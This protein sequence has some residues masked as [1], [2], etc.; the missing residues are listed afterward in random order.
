MHNY[1]CMWKSPAPHELYYFGLFNFVHSNLFHV[2][3]IFKSSP[4]KQ[5]E[6]LFLFLKLKLWMNLS[7]EN[8]FQIS[9]I[10]HQTWTSVENCQLMIVFCLHYIHSLHSPCLSVWTCKNYLPLLANWIHLKFS[11]AH[12]FE[13]VRNRCMFIDWLN[14][15]Q[16]LHLWGCLNLQELNVCL[17]AN[18]MHSKNFNCGVFEFKC[19]K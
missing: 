5:L 10:M 14:A 7:S 2:N 6:F 16:N 13:L 9:T 1:V 4:K 8:I 12:M 3:V 18:W 19:K 11:F 17:F 15:L